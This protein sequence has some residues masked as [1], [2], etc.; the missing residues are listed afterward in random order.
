MDHAR[1]DFLAYAAFSANEHRHIHRRDLQDLLPDAHHL[2]AGGQER[3][4]FGQVI[5]IFAQGLVFLAQLHLLAALQQRRVEFG[6]LEGLGQVI[7]RAQAD[8]FDHRGH[9]IRAG[10]HDD[11]QRAVHLH[12]LPQGFQTIHLRHQHVEN[13]EIGPLSAPESSRALPGPEVTAV[14]S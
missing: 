10:E 1:D 7:L 8:G 12:H 9:F 5:A 11:V 4:V 2:R 6:L 14:T 3:K 13:D